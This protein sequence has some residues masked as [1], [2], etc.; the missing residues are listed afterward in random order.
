[1]EYDYDTFCVLLMNLNT[2]TSFKLFEDDWQ[3]KANIL[4]HNKISGILHKF[5]KFIE[6]MMNY[7]HRWA[8]RLQRNA[9][10]K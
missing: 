1:M 4:S 9:L 7:Y 3:T 2:E 10:I 5:V 8:W 6:M